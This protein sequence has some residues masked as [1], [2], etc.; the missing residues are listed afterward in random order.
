MNAVGQGLCRWLI[1]AILAILGGCSAFQLGYDQAEPVLR[2]WLD[3]QLALNASQSRWLR[4]ELR[5]FHR[6]HRQ[7]ELP[8]YAD[9]AAA[10]SRQSAG[11]ISNVQVCEN[12]DSSLAR[13]DSLLRQAVP[14]FAG[15][16]RQLEPSQLQHLRRRFA[17]EDRAWREKWLDVPAE[18]RTR[19]RLDEWSERAESYYGRLHQGQREFIR[20][21]V[22]RSSWDPQ[23]AWERRQTRQQ[24]IL[25]TLEHIIRQRLGQSDAEA[26][27]QGVIDRSLRPDDPR[28]AAMQRVLQLEACAN[29]AGLHQLTH[30]EQR[31][32]ARDKLASYEKDF[33]QLSAKP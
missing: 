27:I 21:A 33:R 19:Q 20:Q 30:V 28:V 5:Q 11:D 23:L 18:K 13:L 10:F 6:W 3:R 25:A 8:V 31:M 32:R 9:L 1:V 16:A 29:L 24:L 14:L 22:Q 15:L 7:T 26:E 17:E 2:W 12:I 4:E